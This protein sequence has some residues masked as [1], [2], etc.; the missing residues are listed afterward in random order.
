MILTQLIYAITFLALPSQYVFDDAALLKS[1][2]TE[3]LNERLRN[4]EVD[5]EIKIGVIT[6]VSA[7]FESLGDTILAFHRSSFIEEEAWLEDAYFIVLVADKSIC[8]FYSAIDGERLNF[9]ESARF[10][11]EEYGYT[12]FDEGYYYQGLENILDGL[13]NKWGENGEFI[14]ERRRADEAESSALWEEVEKDISG[15][16]FIGL[17]ILVIIAA[18][19]IMLFVGGIIYLV[20][21]IIRRN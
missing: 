21:V 16:A 13:L 18:I 17:M 19:G 14:T 1:E 5:R 6:T 8:Y 15:M 2:E 10:A 20:I 4:L 3:L 12:M 9:P 7:E 11:I